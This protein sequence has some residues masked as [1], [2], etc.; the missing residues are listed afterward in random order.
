MRAPSIGLLALFALTFAQPLEVRAQAQTQWR[1]EGVER[2]VVIPDIHGAFDEFAELLKATGVVDENLD[3]TGGETHLV[4]LGDL[5]DRGPDSRQAMD[6]LM[7]LEQQAPQAGGQ[8]HVILGNHELM[9]MTGDLRYLSEGEYDA[10]AAEEPQAVREMA[11]DWF[12]A[13]A[14]EEFADAEAAREAFREAFPPGYFALRSEFATDG[15]YGRWLLGLPAI[16]VINE[17]AY[18]HA[19][20]PDLVA[21]MPLVDLNQRISADLVAYVRSWEALVAAG[22]L[23]RYERQDP[24]VSAAEALFVADPSRCIDERAAVCERVDVPDEPG[25]PAD[26]DLAAALERF[27]ELS[28]SPV[29]SSGGPMWYRGS[30]LCKP[31]L[32]E[33]VLEAALTR[34]GADRVVVGHTPTFDRRAHSLYDGRLIMMDTGMLVS[35]YGGRPA[36]LIV[37]NGETVVQYLQPEER[38]APLTGGQAIAGNLDRAA[39]LTA[40]AEG[41]VT[42]VGPAG[43]DLWQAR[44]RHDG[45][46]IQ[47]LFY[48]G[49]AGRLEQAA[50][51]LDAL[52]G[53]DL[54]PPTVARRVDDR[55]GALQL[56]YSDTITENQR[57]ANQFAMSGWCPI[58]PQVDLMSM[59][60]ALTSNGSRNAANTLYRASLWSLHLTGHGQAFGSDPALLEPVSELALGP[61]VVAAL[62]ALDEDR[63]EDAMDGLLTRDQIRAL[64]ARRDAILEATGAR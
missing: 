13:Q 17:T 36:A 31:I 33:P 14:P 46:D 32:E 41:E 8:V 34:L 23:P 57:N 5:L 64:L 15:Y 9:V 44:V 52:M 61:G 18:V 30:V 6:L 25:P 3:W 27:I 21:Q 48:A 26:E 1:W 40:L 24:R 60:D 62:R 38:T 54:V 29:L 53:L 49:E 12:V 2:Q 19:G 11:Y 4:S 39:V 42:L 63:L 20:L 56:W 28:G 22:D 51:A 45:E 59:F 35:Y 50:Y 10:F 47:A 55:D 7:R 58:E 37:E 43:L 16:V